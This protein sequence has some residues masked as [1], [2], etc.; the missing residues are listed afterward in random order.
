VAGGRTPAALQ[1]IDETAI[2]PEGA[3][4]LIIVKT[5]TDNGSSLGIV[6]ESE[7]VPARFVQQTSGRA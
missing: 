5:R 4:W 7:R 2:V 3:C 1:S 6:R